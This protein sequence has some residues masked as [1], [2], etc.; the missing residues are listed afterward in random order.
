MKQ[1]DSAVSLLAS[2]SKGVSLIAITSYS[3]SGRLLVN[4][5][6]LEND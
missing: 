5:E 1:V 6:N 2:Y 4:L 3:L